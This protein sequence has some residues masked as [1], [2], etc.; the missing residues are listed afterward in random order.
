LVASIL[1]KNQ[2][3][4]ILDM[5][6]I[7]ETVKGRLGSEEEPFEGEVPI[8]EVETEIV[9]Q[10]NNAQ[11][12]GIRT[13]FVFDNYTHAK[14]SEFLK[15]IEQFGCPEFALFLTADSTTIGSRWL[16]KNDPEGTEIPEE[17]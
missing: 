9:N 1:A 7:S 13:K 2:G 10:I 17:A 14:E 11:K 15:F 8:A 12:S 5:N 3:Y 16:A 4:T 6:A